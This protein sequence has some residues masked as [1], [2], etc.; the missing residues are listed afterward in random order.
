MVVGKYLCI[1]MTTIQVIVCL[2]G[3]LTTASGQLL[4]P[5]SDFLVHKTC[6]KKTH[7]YSRYYSVAQSVALFTSYSV[8]LGHL[9]F[10]LKVLLY[11][12]HLNNHVQCYERLL[13]N[14]TFSLQ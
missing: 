6:G 4:H 9:A 13:N 8:A 1:S 3:P 10:T 12:A 14:F 5:Q 11:S 7:T 2:S